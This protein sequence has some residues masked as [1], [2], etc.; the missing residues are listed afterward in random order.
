MTDSETKLA[1]ANL[2][3]QR[4]VRFKIDAPFFIRLFRKNVIEIKPI[5]PGTIV[6]ISKVI[7]EQDLE[8]ATREQINDKISSVCRIVAMAVLNGKKEMKQVDKLALKLEKQVPV[9]QLFQIYI[10]IANINRHVDFTNITGYFREM[11]NQLMT[12]R[13]PGQNIEGR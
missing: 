11:M 7:L 3:L 5:Y 8:N 2:L 6:E 12:R 9:Y 13:L 1:A 10:H 4:G